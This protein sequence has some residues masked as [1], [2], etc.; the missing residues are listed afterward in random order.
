MSKT[1]TYRRRVE[2]HETDM[3]G[4]VHFSNYFKY[5]EV[6]ECALFRE[7]GFSIAS[8]EDEVHIGWPRGEVSCRFEAPLKFEDE[9][10]VDIAPREIFPKRITYDISIF[11]KMQDDR[12]CVARGWSKA[13]C[14]SIDSKTGKLRAIEIPA[15]IRQ[16]LHEYFEIENKK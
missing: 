2:F 13:I 3:A 14:T 1:F 6:A 10:E 8:V 5:M 15:D 9:V 7:L 4:I 16:K 11:K 12:V